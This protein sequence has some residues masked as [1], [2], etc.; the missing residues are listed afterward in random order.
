MEFLTDP[1]V[2]VGLLTLTLLEIILGIDNLIF[3]AI[4]VDKLPPRKRDRARQLGMCMALLMRLLLLAGIFFLT[5]LTTPLFNLLG[6][7]ISFRELILFIGGLFLLLKATMEIHERLEGT[8]KERDPSRRTGFGS[9]IAQIIA[10][11]VVFSVDSILTAV[12]MT[13]RLGVMMA[14]VVVAMALM[15]V[16]SGI[17]TQFINAR[18][19]LIILCLGFL[20]MI[21]FSLITEGF[22]YHI[23]KAYLYV[24]IGFAAMIE[25]FNQIGLRNRERQLTAT[26]RRQRLADAILYILDGV[27]GNAITGRDAETDPIFTKGGKHKVF[28]PVEKEMIRG[29]L[30]LADRSVSSIMT[31]RSSLDW[32]NLDQSAKSLLAEIQSSCHG[33]LLVSRSSIDN[34]VGVVRKQ[35]LFDLYLGGKAFDIRSVIR[36]PVVVHEASSILKTFELFRLAPALM[37][38][39][40]GGQGKLLGIVTQT[41]LL[42]AIAGDLPDSDR[43]REVAG[44]EN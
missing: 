14:A 3:I 28:A 4:L 41:D 18:P 20:L 44:C 29:V 10:L 42:E 21:G 7:E 40:V 19:S 9:A 11:D 39:V 17:L 43:P 5:T 27:P 6:L 12:G 1:G 13:D 25:A 38:I 22:G 33:Q 30:G 26:Q 36:V 8:P 15:I 16:A 35:D 32:I 31:P 23:P 37:V 2:W 34:L 24:A